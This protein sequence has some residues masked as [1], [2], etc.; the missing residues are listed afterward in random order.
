MSGSR[1]AKIKEKY[2]LMSEPDHI[3]LRPMANLMKGSRPAAF[4][5]FYIGTPLPPRHTHLHAAFGLHRS[6]TSCH[7]YPLPCTH[8]WPGLLSCCRAV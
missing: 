6:S 8:M 2:V 1:R 7:R 5:F 3:W 4:P